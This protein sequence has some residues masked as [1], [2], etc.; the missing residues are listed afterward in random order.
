ME[1]GSG[2]LPPGH[3]GFLGPLFQDERGCFVPGPGNPADSPGG[4]G[5]PGAPQAGSGEAGQLLG[6]HMLGVVILPGETCGEV[7]KTTRQLGS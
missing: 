5:S 4:V 6:Q 7:V 3:P 1:K 2:P